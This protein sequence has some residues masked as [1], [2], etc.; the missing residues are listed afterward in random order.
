MGGNMNSN[1]DPF[2]QYF[3]IISNYLNPVIVFLWRLGLGRLLNLWPGVTGRIMILKHNGRRTGK[4][5]FTPINYIEHEGL[6]YCAASLGVH[7]DW[8]LNILADPQVEVWLPDGW[9]AGHA[10]V[11]DRQ[12]DRLEML[13]VVLSASNVA[14][15]MTGIDLDLEDEEF[16]LAASDYKLISINRQ[17]ARTGV[18]GPGGMAWLWPF[19]LFFM[20]GMRPRR[21]K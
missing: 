7:S 9:Y 12:D 11:I 16:E 21:R 13:R 2:V 1:S 3:P 15:R 5:I 6:I 4:P 10:M 14:A 17:S 18:N 20:L 19:I 8:Y